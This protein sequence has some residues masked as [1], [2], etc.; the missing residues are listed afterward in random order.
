MKTF[1]NHFF[2]S[3]P[4][5]AFISGILFIGSCKKDIGPII[6]VPAN[7]PLVSFANEI[8]PIFNANCV[9]GCHNALP[10][11]GGLELTQDSAYDNLVSVISQIDGNVMRVKPADTDSSILFHKVSYDGIYGLDMPTSGPLTS[12]EV[13]LIKRWINEGALNN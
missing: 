2:K 9:T 13:D 11:P 10:S 7:A 4:A 6:S 3:I 1:S 12:G 8:Q 5:I